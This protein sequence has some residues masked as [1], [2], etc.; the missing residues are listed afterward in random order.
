[1]MCS[2]IL[3]NLKI[4][5]VERAN[6]TALVDRSHYHGEEEYLFVPYSTFALVRAEWRGGTH[7]E[8]HLIELLARPDNSKEKEDLP[9][10]P[11]A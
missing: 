10:A 7:A 4:R 1:M 11:W 8:P 3:K 6:I 5:G 9:T 2:R